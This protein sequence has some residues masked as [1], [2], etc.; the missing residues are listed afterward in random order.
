MSK[1]MGE[2]GC[3]HVR[4]ATIKKSFWGDREVIA[5][6]YSKILLE[7]FAR[8]PTEEHMVKVHLKGIVLASVFLA[9]ALIEELSEK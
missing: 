4:G 2:P 9:D 8:T 3:D 7:P 5:F 6:E 1:G